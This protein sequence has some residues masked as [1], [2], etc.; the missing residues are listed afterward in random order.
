MAKKV[1]K[2]AIFLIFF[3]F[4]LLTV[5][6]T[7][8]GCGKKVEPTKIEFESQTVEAFLGQSIYLHYNVTPEDSDYKLVWS[9]SDGKTIGVDNMGRITALKYG[10]AQVTVSIYETDISATCTVNVTDGYIANIEVDVINLKTT[11]YEGEVVEEGEFSITGNYQS[12]KS[13]KLEPQDYRVEYPPYATKGCAIKIYFSQ[14]PPYKIPLTVIDEQAEALLIKSQP[15]KTSYYV[16]ENFSSEGMEIEVKYSSGRRVVTNDYTITNGSLVY[17]QTSVRIEYGR[18]SIEVPVSVRA[19]AVVSSIYSMQEEI[20]K[21][22]DS[23]LFSGLFIADTP[24]TIDGKSNITLIG[25]AGSALK[26]YNAP[27]IIIKGE[28]QNINLIGFTL[29]CLGDLPCPYL[30]DLSQCTGGD[31]T[32]KNIHFSSTSQNALLMPQNKIIT[33]FIGCSYDN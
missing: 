18:L 5:A 20:D 12:G 19:K 10:S 32:F 26:G 6:L 25:D 27:P 14:M 9:T 22:T 4:L 33:N 30:I 1:Q 24:L 16:G 7:L 28:V 2:N 23:I 3:S 11:Y 17:E 13:A 8:Y 29:A 21:G 15:L 31:V